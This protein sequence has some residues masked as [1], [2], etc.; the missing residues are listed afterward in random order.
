M[1]AKKIGVGIV[2]LSAKGG[3]AS[4]A[5]VPALRALSDRYDIVGL[6]GSSQEAAAAAGEKYGVDFVTD[7][8]AALAARADVDL[9]AVTVKVPFHRELVEAG[10][11]AGKMV[12]CEW[13]LARSL[14]EALLLDG[15]ARATHARCFVGLQAR[16]A[17]PVRFLR[18]L[19]ADGRIG[20]VISTTVMGS[21]GTP[22]GGQATTGSAYATDKE[23]GASMLTIPF[24]HTLDALTFVLG[25]VDRLR[26]TLATR[27][28]TVSLTDTGGTVTATTADQIA[29]QGRLPN[30]SVVAMHYRGGASRGTNFLW[31]INGT[32]GD[33]VVTG[34]VG[35]LQ[36]GWVRLQAAFGDDKTLSDLPVPEDYRKVPLEPTT[37]GYSVA[38]AYRQIS[39]DL[40]SG[41]QEVP[42][43]GDAVRLH[44]L[45]EQIQASAAD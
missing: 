14:D 15:E 20:E 22:W 32:K 7:D 42:G 38:H 21:G 39:D 9:L 23:T 1:S 17:P 11:R 36:W 4:L 16:S 29:V 45:L 37:L 40:A 13:P 8:P 5:H 35:H 12:Y 28:P 27:R 43:F 33:V 10:L 18:D 25:D 34:S 6:S 44:R 3:W 30:G 2:G 19:I 26:S 31:E 41:A 24:G